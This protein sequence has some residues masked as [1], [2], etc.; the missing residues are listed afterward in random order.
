MYIIDIKYN[1]DDSRAVR[2][3]NL[4]PRGFWVKEL[5]YKALTFGSIEGGLQGFKE[6]DPEK[7]RGIFL[8]SGKAAWM[9]GRE[10]VWQD[11]TTLYLQGRPFSRGGDKYFNI[12][13]VLYDSAYE[14]DATFMEDLIATDH[15]ELRHTVGKHDPAETVLT[16]TEFLYQLYRLR[17]RAHRELLAAELELQ[18]AFE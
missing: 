6:Q 8:L 18:G 5:S 2:L 11:S 14:Q 7:Q 1:A 10:V 13:T 16:E 15:E 17:A 12:L 4:T 3:S 9:A